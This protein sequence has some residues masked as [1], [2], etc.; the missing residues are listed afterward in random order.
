[1]KKKNLT[2]VIFVA[3]L[4]LAVTLMDTWIL[5]RQTHNQTKQA[6]SLQLASVSEK[7]E[8]AFSDAQILTA[9][10]AIKARE[11]LDDKEALEKF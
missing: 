8:S 4:L 3:S 11:Y 1:M 10:L 6:G 5:Y 9:E 7:M 2:F